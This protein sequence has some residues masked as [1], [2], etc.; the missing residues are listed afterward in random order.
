MIKSPF[1]ALTLLLAAAAVQ[2]VSAAPPIRIMPLGDSITDGAGA[3][4][5][6][7]L[8]LYQLLTNAGFNVDFV[9]TLTDNGAPGLPDPDHEGHSGWRIDQIDS[10]ILGVFDKDADPDAILVLIGTNDYGQEYD[11]TNAINR[12]EALVLKMA[13]NRPYAKIIVA[14]LLVRGEPYNTQIQTTFN[15]YVPAMVQRQ[16]AAGREVYFTDLR[17]AV[18]L[19]DMPDQLHPDA[20]GYAKMATNWFGAIT[21]LFTPEGSTNPPAIAA[22][23]A[24]AGLTNATVVFSKPTADSSANSANFSLSGGIGVTAAALDSSKRQITLTTTPM[25]QST[26][27]TLTVNGVTDRTTTQQPIAADSTVVFKSPAGRGAVANVAEATNYT[28][29]YSLDIPNLPSYGTGVVYNLDQRTN[30]SGFSRIAYYLELQQNGST[31]INYLWVSMDAFTTNV[32]LIGVPTPDTGAFFQQSITNMNVNSSVAGII[33]GTGLAGGNLEFWPSNSSPLNSARVPNAKDTAYDWGDSP[34]PGNYGCMQVHNHDSSQVLFAFNGWGGAGGIADVGIGNSVG[35]YLD[36]TFSRNATNF[37]IKT[38]QVYVLATPT[39]PT[40]AAAPPIRIMPV[41]DSITDG[42]GAPGGYRLPLYQLLTNAGFNVDYVGTL[43]DN[44]AP[45]LPDPDHE[46]HSGWRIDQIDSIIV[47]AFDSVADPDVILLL[48]GTNDYGQEYDPTNAINR[49]E[50]LVVKMATNRPYAKIIVANLLV[51]GEPYNTQIQTTFNPYVPAMVQRQRAA[52]REVYFTDL[53]S[54]VP[55]SDMPDQL[56]PDALGYAKMAT[57]WFGAMTSLFTPYGSTN[58]PAV[59][60]AYGWLGLTNAT[61]V[62]SKPVTDASANPTNFSISGGVSVLGVVLDAAKRE[63]TLATTPQAPLSTYTVT[64]NGVQDVTPAHLPIAPNSTVV[65]QS[66]I[67]ARGATNT[68]AEATNYTLVYSLEIPANA[69]YLNGVAYDID[70]RADV[71]RFS[72]VAYYVELQEKGKPLNFL[73]VSMDPFTTNI[74]QIGIPTVPSGATFQQ[75]VTNMNVFSSV[76]GIL[77][78]TNLPAGNLEFW[79]GNYTPVNGAGVVNASDAVF[80][81]GDTQSAG[82]YGSMQI[83]NPAA[84]QELIC[85]NNWGGSGGVG[86]LGI[87]NNPDPSGNP[88]WTFA[89]NATAYAIKTLQVYV[90][91]ISGTNAPVL[92]NAKGVGDLTHVVLNFSLPLDDG[93]TNAVHY[94]LNGNVAV[95][96]AALEPLNK[97]TVTLTTTL[98]QPRTAYTATVNGVRARGGSQMPIAPNSTASFTSSPARGAVANVAEAGEYSLVYSLNIPVSPN[99]GGG[100]SYDIDLHS[101]LSGFTR[102]GYYLE[103]Q[104]SNGPLDYVWVSMDAFTTDITRIGVPT[105]PSLNGAIFQ[106]AVS[107]LNVASSVAGIVAGTNL[108]GGYL[109]F[110]PYNYSQGNAESLPN[111]S[112]TAFDWGDTAT[113]SGNYGSMQIANALASQELLCFNGWGGGSSIACI[114]IGNNPSGEPDWT[115]ADNAANFAVRTLQVFAL[116]VANTNSPVLVG[117]VGQTGLTNV[118]INFSKALEDAATNSSNYALDGGVSVLSAALDP[119]TRTAVTLTTSPQQSMKSYTVTVNGVRDGTSAH[120]AI[121]PNST[122]TFRSSIAGRGA[123]N[124]VA[125]AAGYTLVY[126]LDVPVLANYFNGITY[127]IDNSAAIS[128]FSRIAYYVELQQNDKPLNFLWASMEPFTRNVKAIGVPSLASGAVYQ[129]PVGSMNVASSV[130]G[131]VTGTNLVGNL[132]F[133]PY[134]YDTANGAGVTNASS[135]VYD[136]GDTIN[137]GGYHGSMQL[138]N[139]AASQELFCFN[140]WGGG[141]GTAA[142]GIG[143]NPDPAGNPDWTFAANAD[144]YAVKTI[145]VYVLAGQKPFKITAESL[146]GPGQFAVTCDTQPGALYSLWRTSDL[147][148]ASWTKVSQATAVT[149][150]TTFVDPQATSTTSFYQVRTP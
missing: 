121:A 88:D 140:N 36:W 112:D 76:A 47:G 67:A 12:L 110:W 138:A 147:Q 28:L 62:F 73:W 33:T 145:Q 20:L 136:W 19:S 127:N 143:N 5:G 118:V 109:E 60:E 53:R 149:N 34:S 114:G 41:G 132:E 126:S 93:A 52:G 129:Q 128:S 71:S 51:R 7:R 22:A 137:Q 18:P 45:G 38:L 82:N 105:L 92:L 101:Y 84:R 17:S 135:T 59:A 23:Y 70:H 40:L 48:I 103:L 25:L 35:N 81:W 58:A 94:T 69:N 10:I 115:F 141:G 85:Y 72:R 24:W 44:G 106:Q 116:P 102:V 134:N 74:N 30:V 99:Y 68:V 80:D 123:A 65:F 83:A 87:G 13:T 125:E 49:L 66:S 89:G 124:N 43:T 9:G 133:W 8:P 148:S 1:L 97:Q 63:V 11:P 21:N 79:P 56:H 142:I 2:P 146:Q 111:A 78:G 113:T 130:A 77:T 3:P 131:I 95:L 54:A 90:I 108:N 14:N 107:R 91:P 32:N 64:V 46:G 16:R 4:G 29:V 57:N 98:Q 100:V 117:A 50:A 31:A 55:L 96:G 122:A 104:A 61:V 6:Y 119:A 120:L 39:Q 42:V 27:Y 144:T 150:S 75:P 139:A 86:D 26:L 37:T 15:P